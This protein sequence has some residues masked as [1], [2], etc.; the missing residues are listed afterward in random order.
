MLLGKGKWIDLG[1]ARTG[2]TGFRAMCNRD[3]ISVWSRNSA[4]AFWG[5]CSIPRGATVANASVSIENQR[6]NGARI[7]KTG[8][9]G[10]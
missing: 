10:G 3:P 8:A 2:A 6:T 7:A 9:D 5:R 4:G 1:G